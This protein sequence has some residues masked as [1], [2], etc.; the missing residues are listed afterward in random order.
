MAS[1]TSFWSGVHKLCFTV[2]TRRWHLPTFLV[3]CL[4][5]LLPAVATAYEE[6][7]LIHVQSFEGQVGTEN[8]TYYR[9]T[10]DGCVIVRLESLQG[11]ADLYV[12]STSL[13]P[14]WEA[15]D[16]KSNTCG[17]D[18][19]VILPS[20]LR[21]IGIGVY[22]YV[23]AETSVFQL[24]V[25]LNP[26]YSDPYPEL[27][28]SEKFGGAGGDPLKA[29]APKHT[30]NDTSESGEESLLWT[31]FVGFLKILFDVLL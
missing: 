31:L 11:D 1:S 24:S 5:L 13:K 30:T 22:G 3:Y 19:V 15:Y 6:S 20:Q 29:T 8:F 14:T 23:P 18:E 16:F 27:E 10:L 12:S 4:T 21:P 25:F 9:L 26:L 28:D 7:N 2:S 17:T